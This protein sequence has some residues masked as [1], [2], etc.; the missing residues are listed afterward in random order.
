MV[1]AVS[2]AAALNRCNS[3]RD[4]FVVKALAFSLRLKSL[5]QTFKLLKTNLPNQGKPL[6]QPGV[7]NDDSAHLHP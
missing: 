3:F 2:Y 1:S 4:L 5:L 7:P 6:V